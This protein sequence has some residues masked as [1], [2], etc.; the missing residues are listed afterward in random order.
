M[1]VT[2]MIQDTIIYFAVPAIASP[3]AAPSEAHCS[4]TAC[5]PIDPI[6]PPMNE[7]TAEPML[8]LTDAVPLSP[9]AISVNTQH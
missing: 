9:D 1:S 6:A 2:D 5:P 8:V 4:A 7:P 3:I